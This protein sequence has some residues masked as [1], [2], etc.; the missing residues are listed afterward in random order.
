[1]PENIAKPRYL[2]KSRFK[3]AVECP[4]KLF[5][6]GKQEYGNIKQEDS[7]LEMLAEGGFQVGE[8]AKL[9]FPTGYEIKS[10]NHEEAEYETTE[11]LKRD[12]VI[13]F[14][15]AIRFGNLFVRVDILIKRN[16]SFELIEVK[17]KSYDSLDPKLE[18]KSGGVLTDMLPYIQDVA[19]QTYVLKNAYPNQSVTSYLMMPD[20]SLE[21][22]ISGLNQFFKIDKTNQQIQVVVDPIAGSGGFGT[23]LL[24]K[25]NVDHL[26][27]LINSSGIEF[28]GGILPL[29]SAANIWADAYKAD[30]MITPI[31]GAQCAKCEFRADISD[32]KKSGFHQCW[33]QSNGWTDKDFEDGTVLDLWNFRGKDVVIQRGARRLT[34]ITQSDIKYKEGDDG[35]SNTERQW[36]QIA[37]IAKEDDKGGFYLDATFMQA[38]MS[39]WKYPYHFIDFE[40]AAVALPFFKGMRPYEQI[41][42]QFSHHVMH[43]SGEVHHVDEFLLV[44]PG[45]FPNYEFARA[46]KKSLE[47]DDGTVFMWSL[48]ENTIL[49]KIVQQLQ[50][51]F[52]PPA[53]KD[54]LV[55]FMNTLIKGGERA[56][57]D[58][59][60]L[61]QK[62]YFHPNTKASSSI[63]KVLPAILKTS[64]KL[65][66]K[67]SQPIYGDAEAITSLNYK[68][69]VWW[70]QDLDGEVI[71]PYEFLQ[72]S[73][74]ALLGDE[75]QD[76]MEA[77]DF[78]IAEGGAA[79]TAYSRLQFESLDPQSREQIKCALLRY[80][81]LDTLAMVMIV[82]AWKEQSI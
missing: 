42:F 7:F 49:A 43:K 61:A 13:L 54:E 11:L 3:L 45:Q 9:M 30:Q 60:V 56:M 24:T 55:T 23:P 8:L 66:E 65:R 39:S 74:S 67:Y 38:E 57:V 40:T 52:N 50:K 17:A 2:T 78:G 44:E 77:E 37:G 20:K 75:A 14:E 68:N 35:L 81:E 41:A 33:K 59:R 27:G 5:Y 31:I 73:A 51:E 12:E 63:K 16:N 1:M 62:A 46:L 72:G 22:S 29:S 19:F 15:P 47:V 26:I 25:V 6:T 82:E 79:A 4:T 36:M 28:P 69:F 21:A 32:V 76:Y 80:C 10:K 18:K 53:D 34:Q 70:K 71:D 48:H 58:L 64:I